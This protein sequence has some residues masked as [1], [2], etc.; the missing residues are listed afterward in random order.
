MK[1]ATCAFLPTST[2]T[3]KVSWASMGRAS[4]PRPD[5]DVGG[6][7][8]PCLS[9]IFAQ[10]FRDIHCEGGWRSGTPWACLYQLRTRSM[11]STSY[12]VYQHAPPDFF[13]ESSSKAVVGFCGIFSSRER[14]H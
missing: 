10:H 7:S 9:R 6:M 11:A 12:Q 4:G 13:Q 3:Y 1:P 8:R 14:P 2:P 5:D